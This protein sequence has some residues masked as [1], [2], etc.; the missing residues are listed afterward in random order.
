M[1]IHKSMTDAVSFIEQNAR[2]RNV[3]IIGNRISLEW[4]NV[5]FYVPVKGKMKQILKN[6]S[7]HVKPRECVAIM[8]PSGSGKTTL[9]N[10]IAQRMRVSRGSKMTG[11]VK[12]NDQ[13][14]TKE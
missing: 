6:S 4:E 1:V 14:L 8:G 3:S 7:G 12:I 13:E 10:I 5:N 11:I 9:L 2:E